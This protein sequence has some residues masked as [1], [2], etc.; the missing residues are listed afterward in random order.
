MIDDSRRAYN[1]ARYEAT[2]EARLAYQRAYYA[3]HRAERDAA[4]RAARKRYAE[5]H[6]ERAAAQRKAWKVKSPDAVKR[7]QKTYRAKNRDRIVERESRR[8]GVVGVITPRPA[9][10]D[11]CGQPPTGRHVLHVDH[12][13]TTGAFRGWLCRGC[14]LAI[15]NV[16]EAPAAL[17]ALASYL[18]RTT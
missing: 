4:N 2:R 16:Q 17:R 9:V 8:R 15:G 1:R 14:N 6:P 5:T 10:C 13:H 7:H 12:S 3:K 18:E 11:S